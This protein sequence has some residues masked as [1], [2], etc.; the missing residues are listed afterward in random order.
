MA[1]FDDIYRLGTAAALT[2]AVGGRRGSF[3][4]N[5]RD[6]DLRNCAEFPRLNIFNEWRSRQDR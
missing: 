6:G 1:V 5:F 4:C 3:N 2:V